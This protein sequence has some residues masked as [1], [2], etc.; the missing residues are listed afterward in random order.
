M[1]NTHEWQLGQTVVD[2]TLGRNGDEPHGWILNCH[3]HRHKNCQMVRSTSNT[4]ANPV[5]MPLNNSTKVILSFGGRYQMGCVDADGVCS[6][7]SVIAP[8]MDNVLTPLE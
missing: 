8:K 5:P 1:Q 6:M 4:T 2:I 3:P 7:T